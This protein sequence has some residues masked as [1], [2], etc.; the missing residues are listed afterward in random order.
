VIERLGLARRVQSIW[1]PLRHAYLLIVVMIG[2]VFFRAE[3]LPG[4]LGMLTAMTGLGHAEPTVYDVTWYLT[5][6]VVVAMVTGI[7][8]ATPI[9][10]TLGRILWTD[11]DAEASVRFAWLPSAAVTAGLF[12]LLF[13]SVMLSAARTYNPFIYFRF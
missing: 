5:P 11:G 2:W 10:P 8:A 3:T 9:A 6:E 12:V 7:V 1:S 13:A 4:A